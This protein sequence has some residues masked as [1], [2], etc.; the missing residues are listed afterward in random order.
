[1]FHSP[2]PHQ[3]RSRTAAQ[4]A[5]PG[6]D[7]PAPNAA[8]AAPPTTTNPV[9]PSNEQEKAVDRFRS[10]R[11]RL[12]Q[13]L[14][15]KRADQR[16][17]ELGL[18]VLQ[19]D[20][21]FRNLQNFNIPEDILS[22]M[23]NQAIN[24]L[25]RAFKKIQEINPEINTI[26]Q[27]QNMQSQL[28][29]ERSIPGSSTQPV[30]S[31]TE[32][33]ELIPEDNTQP[34][35]TPAQPPLG[36]QNL[37]PPPL[38]QPPTPSQPSTLT[39]PPSGGAPLPNVN[40][41][42]SLN[43]N[44]GSSQQLPA[45]STPTTN[46]N[47]T[48]Q[49]TP[50]ANQTPHTTPRTRQN[51][52]QTSRYF[53]F[54]RTRNQH[55]RSASARS[56]SARSRGG[57]TRGT[58]QRGRGRGRG[59]ARTTSG[60]Q[61]G[62]HD[63]PG[64]QANGGQTPGSSAYN[65]GQFHQNQY[66]HPPGSSAQNPSTFQHPAPPNS[67]YY[68]PIT[69]PYGQY[70]PPAPA[71]PG[72]GPP[73]PSGP[74][75]TRQESV[76]PWN[77]AFTGPN[78]QPPYNAGPVPPPPG[79]FAMGSNHYSNPGANNYSNAYSQPPPGAAP[80]GG[81]GDYYSNAQQSYSNYNSQPP[82]PYPGAGGN[83][84]FWQH[85]TNND[86]DMQY[87]LNFPGPWR[88]PPP[89]DIPPQ[90]KYLDPI[91]AIERGLI[92][93]FL[94]TVADYPRFY[95]SF[96]NVVHIQP[97][98]IFYKILALDRLITDPKT[99]RLFQGLGNSGADYVLRLE[100]L[101]Q[102]YGGLDRLR[103][104]QLRNLREIKGLI[105]QNL[106]VFQNYT[107]SLVTFLRNS[108]PHEADNKVLLDYIKESMSHALL[109]Q[110]NQYLQI[111]R[112]PDNNRTMAHFLSFRLD[113]EVKARENAQYQR[114]AQTRKRNL[115]HEHFFHDTDDTDDSLEPLGST[116]QQHANTPV[117][118]QYAS[119]PGPQQHA[120][121]QPRKPL[122]PCPCCQQTTHRLS[123]CETFYA[124]SPTERRTF[125]ANQGLCFTCMQT[126]HQSQGCPNQNA[127]CGICGKRH[128][129]LL[130]LPATQAQMHAQ[131]E[132]PDLID[133]QVSDTQHLSCGYQLAQENS[134]ALT[135]DIALT[136][137]TVWV[138]NP[139]TKKRLKV[140]LLAD[141]GANT[142]CLDSELGKELGLTGTK[143]PYHVQ[144]GGGQ[145]HSYS[146]YEA[147]V[148]I[149]GVHKGAK[150]YDIT[151]HVYDKPCGK[152]GPIDWSQAKANW[153]HLRP[154]DLPK[155]ADRHIQGIIGT[156]DFLLL[157]P[158]TAA[159]TNGRHDP[160]AFL[161]PLGWLI[162]GQIKPFALHSTN[163]H[164]LF[165][166]TDNE[167]CRHTRAALERLWQVEPFQARQTGPSKLT[168]LEIRAEQVFNDTQIQRPDGKYEVGLLWKDQAHLPRNYQFALDAFY[169]LE[170]Q[171]DRHPEMRR[172][173]VNT[174][175]D[176]LNKDI[177]AYIST[178]QSDIRYVIPT[179][180][181]V[182]LDK[183]TTSYRL[184]VDGARR[185]RGT[186]IN[187]KLMPGPKLI[188]NLFDILIRFR[189]GKFAFTCD[190]HSMYLNVKVPERDQRYLC[191]FYRESSQHPL[192]ILRLSSH[193]FGLASSPYV[194]MKVVQQHA[195]RHAASLPLAAKA[196]AQGVLVDDFILSHDDSRHLHHTQIQL[197]QLLKPIGMNL[198]KMAANSPV[199][200]ADIAPDK[201]AKTKSL[202]DEEVSE[203]DEQLPTIK[204]L[205][206]VWNA[207][208][209]TVAIQ[210][211][212][213]HLEGTLTLRQAVSEGGRFYDP[214]G[215]ALPIA[216]SSRIMLQL[217]WSTGKGWDEPLPAEIQAKWH[218][219]SSNTRQLDKVHIPR[220]IKA[221]DK[222]VHSQRLIIFVDASSE[223]QAAVAYIQTCYADNSLQARLL[224]AKGKVTS[225]RKQ[226][227]I[228]R[229]ECQA[230]AM[231][232]ELGSKL[233][234]LL[235]WDPAQV[236][237][238]SDSTTT[239]WWIRTP[240]PLKIFVANRVCK[241]LDVSQVSQWKYIHTKDNPADLPTRTCSLKKWAHNSLWWW[242]P[243]FL[244]LPDDQWPP[245]P[246]VTETTEGLGETR[247]PESIL[248]KIH[249]HTGPEAPSPGQ[250]E[251]RRIW[252]KYESACKGLTIASIVYYAARTWR[253]YRRSPFTKG[254]DFKDME[255][256]AIAFL[257]K[258]DQ[259][260]HLNPWLQ[261]AK[262]GLHGPKPYACWRPFLD[263]EGLLRI[264]GRLTFTRTLAPETRNPILL[265]AAMPMAK[266][267]LRLFHEQLRHVGGPNQLLSNIRM[268]YWIHRGLPLAKL[269]IKQCAWCQSRQARQIARQ[270]APLHFTR[271]NAPRGRVFFSIGI[272]MFGP[273][274][275]TQGRGK[276]RGKRYGL[277]FT[278]GFS[279]AIN[280]EVM[281][282]ATAESCLLAFKRHTAMYGQPE[283]I[284]SDQGTNLTYVRKVLDEIQTVWED[285]QPL[286]RNH[287]PRIKWTLNPPYTPSYGGHYESLIKVLK[288]A[289][290]HTARW[291]KYLFNDDQLLT[292]LKEA[293]AIANMRPL[294]QTSPNPDDPPPLRPSDF[295]NAP[296][297]GM[298]PDWR[299]TTLH[300]RIKDELEAFQQELWVRMRK[301]VLSGL[302]RPR[303]WKDDQS[304][305][306]GDLVLYNNDTWRPD[307]WPMARIVE[308]LPSQDGKTRTVKI[309][310]MDHN[311][312]A[313][314]SVQS[315]RN[316]YKLTLPEPPANDRLHL[317]PVQTETQDMVEP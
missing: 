246:A 286:L 194:A 52:P 269:V 172:Q 42:S 292:G 101:E 7:N 308:L 6:A 128:H 100:R 45:H 231:G 31:G 165:M 303:T 33:F 245:Q 297:V 19:V 278:C 270:T 315:T 155:A 1:M 103:T 152:L 26:T 30:T 162:G 23:E 89:G 313:K 166:H 316:L 112:V 138:T 302:Q 226:E 96:Y 282:D 208:N 27:L 56:T 299:S 84:S 74:F 139:L 192:K 163:T 236:V 104:H 90:Y 10:S 298:V 254:L 137:A 20:T 175:S 223:A 111:H 224:A 68:D 72:Y 80:T 241:I 222:P 202:G 291:P 306:E 287:F 35:S 251:L 173:F 119:A 268:E 29:H 16:L 76:S 258:G 148:R 105:D 92:K 230:A 285:A 279:R 199:I 288:N 142:S 107:H 114:D 77:N 264:N 43:T 259:G 146:S 249:L 184:V 153:E 280:V 9:L 132:D 273:M 97:G 195:Q 64:A 317:S 15:K 216:M 2:N 191:I 85:R 180:M 145:I 24:A 117:P 275:V 120:N 28:I 266:E 22:D 238:F 131:T 86:L 127:R 41:A 221:P 283:Y 91:R 219:W 149:E 123:N 82:P 154:L 109:V 293:A 50:S 263:E 67:S 295:L 129:F 98:P 206:L 13:V 95:S 47:Q 310:M 108:P 93:P 3:T 187:D 140:N 59:T 73:P 110:Y 170:R 79:A 5:N 70:R 115:V 144:V 250:F 193:P 130:H 118:Q 158:Q 307:F 234:E 71:P 243:K 176:W 305:E 210:Y 200:L 225:L 25:D 214:L 229:L 209:D 122:P 157:S 257:L 88:M 164:V 215:L 44:V 301:E 57:G 309:K 227:S 61:T 81:Y 18:T 121:A 265:T 133:F 271:E 156:T 34:A 58:S 159:I 147:Q 228:P 99:T 188:Q 21:N 54:L 255:T 314:T 189:Q 253:V 211:Q 261:A 167:C 247:T 218:S 169:H 151:F 17:S 190:I 262:H 87:S 135:L 277:I 161:S 205:G 182:R 244:T 256:K 290:K 8:S 237:Y 160:V 63:L 168:P 51:R 272:D 220:C 14:R 232:A 75:P 284:N 300:R 49:T 181:V 177:A 83:S 242:G 276:R 60:L 248:Q 296:I 197:Q 69:D 141:T 281:R 201:I 183:V 36:S 240:K 217:C 312:Q 252:S 204:T 32:D 134:K 113:S 12:D 203:T 289:F 239:L 294:T 174:I 78:T 48:D 207:Q 116:Q 235:S 4:S 126:G 171:M 37:Q 65:S 186:C 179:F 274:E 185:H 46:Q 260:L 55:Q 304:L 196:V 40:T 94:G 38:S 62:N 124:M 143:Q 178:N 233:S 102:T 213:Q 39:Q 53:E 311:L 136:V 212:P 11:I 150:P 106:E 125:A 66:G 267:I 198:H